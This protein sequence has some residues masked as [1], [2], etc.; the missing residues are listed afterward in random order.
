MENGLLQVGQHGS[1]NGPLGAKLNIHG[2]HSVCLHPVFES[3]DE[4]HTAQLSTIGLIFFILCTNS[5][6]DGPTSDSVK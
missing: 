1:L 5:H 6:I 3:V 2:R 4:K